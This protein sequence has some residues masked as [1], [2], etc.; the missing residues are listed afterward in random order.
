[1]PHSEDW[2]IRLFS[3]M[4]TGPGVT[5]G[6]GDDCAIINPDSQALLTT[7]D[8][9]VEGVHFDTIWHKPH[10]LGR[11]AGAVNLSDIAAMGGVPRYALLS[12]SVHPSVSEE[13]L[14]KLAAGFREILMEHGVALVGGNCSSS[15]G[16]MVLAVTLMGTMPSAPTIKPMLRSGAQAGDNIWVS[17]F[18]GDARAALH[19]LLGSDRL[20]HSQLSQAPP[21]SSPSEPQPSPQINSPIALPEELRKALCD[22]APMVK[23]GQR[24]AQTGLIHACM[25]LSDGLFTDLGRLVKAA[26]PPR[27]MGSLDNHK[28]LDAIINVEKLPISPACA[29][30]CQSSLQGRAM[31]NAIIGGEDYQL[32]VAAAPGE[33][34][35]AILGSKL[36]MTCIGHLTAGVGEVHYVWGDGSQFLVNEKPFEHF[37]QPR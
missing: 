18:L 24:L 37:Q 17:G 8:T 2:L 36:G 26:L 30:Y 13:F 25:D 27:A 22:P 20:S 19:H 5:L 33:K 7:T 23:L 35:E 31:L 16:P 11:K 9:M 6:I 4:D 34:T 15:P 12:I 32:L 21:S 28:A 1:M 3:G 29:A 10:E 14:Q